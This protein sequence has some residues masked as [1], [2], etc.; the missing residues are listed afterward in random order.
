LL[1]EALRLLIQSKKQHSPDTTEKS[2]DVKPEAQTTNTTMSHF[3]ASVEQN[4]QLGEL[5][6]KWRTS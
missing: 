6:A 4:Y 2:S 1:E 5:L 3:Q